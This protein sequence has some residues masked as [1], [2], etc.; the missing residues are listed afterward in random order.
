[1][2]FDG[3]FIEKETGVY[4]LAASKHGIYVIMCYQSQSFLIM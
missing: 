3:E 4:E 1:M 2:Q